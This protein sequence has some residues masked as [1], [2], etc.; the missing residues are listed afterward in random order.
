MLAQQRS[1]YLSVTHQSYSDPLEKNLCKQPPSHSEIASFWTPLPLG[2][3]VALRGGGG[4]DIFWNYT[5][6]FEG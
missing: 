2:I 6:L 1:W 3:S 5:L 4:M